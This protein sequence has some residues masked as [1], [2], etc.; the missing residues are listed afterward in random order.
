MP[1]KEETPA[2]KGF[3]LMHAGMAVCCTVMLIPVAGFFIAG[4]T[5]AGLVGNLG[6]FAP[7]AICI[8]AQV[9]MFAFTGK[10]CHG[11]AKSKDTAEKEVTLQASRIPVTRPQQHARETA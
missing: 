1:N 6:I 4:G 11:D 5:I 10:S 2:K 8:G 3:G 7:I 9:A